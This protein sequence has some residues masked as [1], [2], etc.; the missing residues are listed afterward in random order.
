[1]RRSR[2]QLGI[3][4]LA[5]ALLNAASC[6]SPVSLVLDRAGESRA[7]E[8]V[9]L[10]IGT[11]DRSIDVLPSKQS[12]ESYLNEQASPLERDAFFIFNA[13]HHLLRQWGNTI[14]PNGFSFTKGTI[15][16]GT[17]LYH[18]RGNPNAPPSPEWLAF[19]PEMSYAI[20][21]M[22]CTTFLQTY[23]V[24]RPLNI[25]Y[26]DG[27]SASLTSIGTLDSQDIL[28]YGYVKRRTGMFDE[29]ERARNLCTWGATRGIDGFV[30]QNSGFE[31]I[32]CSFG[33]GLTLVKNL[34]VTGWAEKFRAPGSTPRGCMETWPPDEPK[35]GFVEI[36]GFNNIHQAQSID[37]A[38]PP[39]E[40]DAGDERPPPPDFPKDGPPRGPRFPGR[41]GSGP[42]GP[43]FGSSSPFSNQIN[44]EWARAATTV[45]NGPG[46]FR[47]KLDTGSFVTAYGREGLGDS[48]LSPNVTKH[49]LVDM[50]Q[51]AVTELIREIDGF[52]ITNQDSMAI[53]GINWRDIT[54]QIV[55]RY[56]DRLPELFS[57]LFAA[58][59]PR[60]IAD[61][62][63]TLSNF[64]KARMV[65]SV[66]LVP[67]QDLGLA[68]SGGSTTE[69]HLQDCADFWVPNI[70]IDLDNEEPL[71]PSE[72][73]IS[74]AL[75]TVQARICETLI[76]VHEELSRVATSTLELHQASIDDIRIA[77]GISRDRVSA[78]MSKLQWSGWQSCD[79]KCGH[80][81]IC[82]ITLWP[83]SGT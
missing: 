77:A 78:L 36:S 37:S 32:K 52:W 31:L 39:S 65:L 71:Y 9:P 34:N 13:V 11:P 6:Q 82:L 29:F 62:N 56:G 3:C 16:T 2:I 74:R 79:R 23:R 26:I 51:E 21:S 8:Q 18:A 57:S 14:A 33:D 45:Y 73:K 40:P 60:S 17:N 4:F 38:G 20:M 61:A 27:N 30:R 43:P 19:D 83:I 59:L 42:R 70:E 15:P 7:Q 48:V 41:G 67:H 76:S 54:D 28:M 1:M 12:H 10:R 25:L 47:V 24:I 75:R 64:E 80:D 53:S 66:L 44:F 50:T 22:R 58:S 68:L 63:A 46:E 55:I 72:K 69:E 5:S 35:A 49:R 81:E